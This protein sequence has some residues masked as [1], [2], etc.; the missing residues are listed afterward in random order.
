MPSFPEVFL[1]HSYALAF[2]E[3]FFAVDVCVRSSAGSCS[4]RPFAGAFSVPSFAE[5]FPGVL[6]RGLFLWVS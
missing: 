1:V 2:S 5:N 3:R 6:F 4:V